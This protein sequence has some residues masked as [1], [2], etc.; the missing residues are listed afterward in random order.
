[1]QDQGKILGGMDREIESELESE[2]EFWVQKALFETTSPQSV[3]TALRVRPRPAR[4]SGSRDR[5]SPTRVDHTRVTRDP[6][7][8]RSHGEQARWAGDLRV[9]LAR[10][11]GRLPD[12]QRAAIRRSLASTNRPSAA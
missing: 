7:V 2:M 9:G 5:S 12:E 11:L 10:A 1:M 3:G 4:R 8:A 6:E